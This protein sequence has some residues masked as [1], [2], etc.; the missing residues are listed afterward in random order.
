MKLIGTR[1]LEGFVENNPTKILPPRM[2]GEQSSPPVYCSRAYSVMKRLSLGVIFT[3]T[4]GLFEAIC[5]SKFGKPWKFYLEVFVILQLAFM[6]LSMIVWGV[7]S[8]RPFPRRPSIW[9]V[10]AW[11]PFLVLG[12]YLS[13]EFTLT[14]AGWVICA[15]PFSG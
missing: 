1:N 13:L 15:T 7:I 12:L 3:G 8:P 4:I 10:F 9:L 2:A 5:F 6:P 11:S 14:V